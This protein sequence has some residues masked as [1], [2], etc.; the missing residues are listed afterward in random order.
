M[1]KQNHRQAADAERD[2]FPVF[3]VLP[4]LAAELLMKYSGCWKLRYKPL[5]T[6]YYTV[7]VKTLQTDMYTR[8]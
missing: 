1:Y 5:F 8:L 7:E 6:E 4:I 2:A 3:H